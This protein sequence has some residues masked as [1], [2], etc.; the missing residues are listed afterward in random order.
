MRLR[1]SITYLIAESW[2]V[3]MFSQKKSCWQNFRDRFDSWTALQFLKYRLHRHKTY[4][5]LDVIEPLQ[6]DG[7]GYVF[8]SS[9]DPQAYRTI[10]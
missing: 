8:D 5:V 1:I 6:Y 10:L 7:R 2:W 9:K 3:L 4:I